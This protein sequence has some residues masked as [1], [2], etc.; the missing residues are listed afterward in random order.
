MSEPDRYSDGRQRYAVGDRIIN[1]AHFDKYG[2]TEP[3]FFPA[4]GNNAPEG[5]WVSDKNNFK[6]ENVFD[7][8][9]GDYILK[10][11]DT[12]TQDPYTTTFA[13]FKKYVY[14][15]SLSLYDVVHS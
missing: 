11:T 10:Y 1:E 2:F 15:W 9:G 7:H 5:L 13:K 3:I 4:G 12:Q 14:K 8:I 6:I